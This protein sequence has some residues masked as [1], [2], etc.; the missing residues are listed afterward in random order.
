MPTLWYNFYITKGVDMR[1]NQD[2]TNVLE[3]FGRNLTKLANVQKH[4]H[5]YLKQFF[6]FEYK[7]IFVLIYLKLLVGNS[8]GLLN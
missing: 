5:H 8:F 6:P 1:I 2:N 7:L 3:K 4:Y